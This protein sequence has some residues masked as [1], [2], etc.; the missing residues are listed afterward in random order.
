MAS[1][2]GDGGLCRN[3]KAPGQDADIGEQNLLNR[4]VNFNF[5]TPGTASAQPGPAGR[6]LPLGGIRFAVVLGGTDADS[7]AWPQINGGAMYYRR[8]RTGKRTFGRG[9]VRAEQPAGEL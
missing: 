5:P 1:A 4:G 9:C 2:D 6:G 8:R 7:P 3:D